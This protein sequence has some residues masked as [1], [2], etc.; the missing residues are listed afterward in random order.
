M[1]SRHKPLAGS[2]VNENAPLAPPVIFARG[3]ESDQLRRRFA[4]RRSFLLHQ[5]AAAIDRRDR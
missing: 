2:G 4:A 1:T 3:E 5:L